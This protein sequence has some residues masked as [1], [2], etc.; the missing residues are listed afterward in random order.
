MSVPFSALAATP[1]QAP[2][3]GSISGAASNSAGRTIANTTVRLRDVTTGQLAATTTSNAA[4]Q[5]S[6]TG[7]T[8][9]SY[10][11]EVVNA[12]GQIIGTSSAITVGVGAAVTGVSVASAAMA[13]ASGSFFASTA[14]ILAVAAAGAAVAGVTVAANRPTASGSK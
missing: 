2:S 5:F 1:G 3:T 8:A 6:F 10:T 13:A 9:G 12:A 11:V 14:G 4:G 7:L